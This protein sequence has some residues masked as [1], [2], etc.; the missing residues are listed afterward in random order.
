MQKLENCGEQQNSYTNFNKYFGRGH[1]QEQNQIFKL[2]G[3]Y[4]STK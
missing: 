4:S 1:V 3:A 2:S